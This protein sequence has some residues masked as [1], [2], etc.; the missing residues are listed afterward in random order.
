MSMGKVVAV[1]SMSLDGFIAGPDDDVQRLFGWF[2]SGDTD[3]PVADGAMVLKL[4]SASAELFRERYES[5]GA[6]VSGR[7]MFDVAG[8]WGGKHPQDV[9][10]FVVTHSVPQE[11]VYEGSPFTFVTD[12]V[13][14]AVEKAK[15]TAGDKNVGVGGA[16]ITQQC[17]QAGLLDEIQIDLVPVL[18]GAGIRLFDHIGTDPIDLENPGVIE[19][20]GVTHLRF[21]V[22]KQLLYFV[23]GG[24]PLTALTLPLVALIHPTS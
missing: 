17:I 1:F 12:G 6:I 20:S 3:F 19:D 7:R 16:N 13:E 9:P 23:W 24:E 2:F 21:R 4:S 11:W 18:V 5:T 8:A 15:Q 14:S 10:V 22:V